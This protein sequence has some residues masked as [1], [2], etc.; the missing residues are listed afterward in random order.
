MWLRCAVCAFQQTTTMLYAHTHCYVFGSV[1]SPF[2]RSLS[3]S[4]S[5]SSLHSGH[6]GDAMRRQTLCPASA[7]CSAM[8]P[9]LASPPPSLS[10]WPRYVGH[11]LRIHSTSV[12]PKC[13]AIRVAGCLAACPV[14]LGH[15]VWHG[16]GGGAPAR[17]S[18]R[19]WKQGKSI[20]EDGRKKHTRTLCSQA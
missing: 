9:R 1:R 10:S 7:P 6:I 3:L 18:R 2:F 8:H 17:A 5:F 11:V 15:S 20:D 14:L 19:G 4:L 13:L 16:R 12:R